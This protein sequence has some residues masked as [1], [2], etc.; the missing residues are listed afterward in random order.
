MDM[1]E[2]LGKNDLLNRPIFDSVKRSDG[3]IFQSAFSKK[4]IESFMGRI[5]TK[6][7]IIYNGSE[8]NN[9]EKS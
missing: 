6:S 5:S 2:T 3:I 4:L 7:T 8:I 9:S 1:M